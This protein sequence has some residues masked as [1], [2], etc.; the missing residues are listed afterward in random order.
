[1]L[2]N[3]Q[4]VCVRV[5]ASVC[6]CGVVSGVAV[7]CGDVREGGVWVWD[8]DMEPGY[9]MRMWV[10]GVVRGNINEANR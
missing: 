7:A 1:M 8:E 2:G 6:A 3:D 9:V 5:C 10:W 4:C